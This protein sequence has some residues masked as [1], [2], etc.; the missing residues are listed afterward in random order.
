[1]ANDI[2][3]GL[4]SFWAAIAFQGALIPLALVLAW[5]FGLTPWADLHAAGR[6]IGLAVALTVPMVALGVVLLQLP[7]DWVR[8]LE[9][10]VREVF[11]PLF[12]RVGLPGIIMVSIL[13]GV[14][15]ELL[16][17]GV[18]QEAL[19]A[20]GADVPGFLLASVIFGLCHFITPAYFWLATG[21]GLYLGG[22][23]VWTG[24]L[25]VPII[26]HGLYDFV[27]LS[28]YWFRYRPDPSPSANEPPR[29]A[30]DEVDMP[31]S[32]GQ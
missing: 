11:V 18:V 2:S 4:S 27:I 8:D 30:P 23:Y 25:L 1:M 19:M 21:M 15:E 16:F 17:R 12:H 31:S 10:R 14:G 3:A 20:W 7:Y 22:L 29:Q 24:N 32:S 28:Y 6:D 26:V 5:A 9:A 13:A